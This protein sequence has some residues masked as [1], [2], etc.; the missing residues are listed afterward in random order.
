MRSTISNGLGGLAF[1]VIGALVLVVSLRSC[2]S[3]GWSPPPDLEH[4]AIKGDDGRVFEAYFFPDRRAMFWY[5]N[6]ETLTVEG[7]LSSVGGLRG[8]HYLGNLWHVKAPGQIINFGFYPSGCRPVAIFEETLAT[9]HVG[10]GEPTF[11]PVGR[12]TT[13]VISFC[14]DR[15][16]FQG[17]PLLRASADPSETSSRLSVLEDDLLER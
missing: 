7:K 4:Y 3:T 17:M 10:P 13:S 5:T 6:P 12:A 8:D 16:H 14:P 15:I 1:A 11:P 2:V 9:Y